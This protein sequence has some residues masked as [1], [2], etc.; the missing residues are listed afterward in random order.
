MASAQPPVP[1]HAPERRS[2]DSRGLAAGIT[3]L[4]TAVLAP[5]A[6]MFGLSTFIMA[7][8][9]PL[10]ANVPLP[11][12]SGYWVLLTVLVGLLA[13]LVLTSVITGIVAIR[14]S[15][16]MNAG[17]ITGMLGLA[18]TAFNMTGG[19]WTWAGLAGPWPLLG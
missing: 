10:L 13:G 16:R 19:L 18:F 9:E 5:V 12:T 15:Q 4:V 6:A 17:R 11:D 3:S 8:A 14:R 2:A 7:A 1:P